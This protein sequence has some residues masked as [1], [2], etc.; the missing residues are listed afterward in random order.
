MRSSQWHRSTVLLATTM[1]LGCGDARRADDGAGALHD[2]GIETEP[3]R[4]S[5][6]DRRPKFDLEHG[7]LNVD[8]PGYA[9]RLGVRGVGRQ[10]VIATADRASPA[11]A[12]HES[13]GRVRYPYAGFSE[14]FLPKGRGVEH[15]IDVETRPSGDGWLRVEIDT[16]GLTPRL[17]PGRGRVELNHPS[18][19]TQLTYGDLAVVDATGRRL[20]ARFAVDA[21]GLAIEVADEGA[22]YPLHIDPLVVGLEEAVIDAPSTSRPDEI[23]IATGD[24]L[25]FIGMPSVSTP[26]GANVG[27]VLVY[28]KVGGSWTKVATV[29]SSVDAPNEWFGSSV[30][31]QAGTLYVGA[32][33]PGTLDPAHSSTTP[34]DAGTGAVTVFTRSG[35]T[36]TQQALLR[37]SD[38]APGDG[39][40]A[41]LA[42]SGNTLAVAQA[43]AD[44]VILPSRVYVFE[45]TGGS[46]SASAELTPTSSL[47]NLYAASVAL[48]G[49][50]L[51]VGAPYAV[52]GADYNVGVGFVFSRG[53]SGWTQSAEL[54]D[55]VCTTTN[56]YFGQGVGVSGGTVMIGT[57]YA[58]GSVA[59]V[60]VYQNVAGSWTQSQRLVAP[61]SATVAGSMLGH[62]LA[63]A[64]TTAWI[65]DPSWSGTIAGGPIH[66]GG[67]LYPATADASG[68]WSL[69]TPV[70]P[71]DL[72]LRQ[73]LGFAV[74]F[75]GDVLVGGD[76]NSMTV[77]GVAAN[78]ARIFGLGHPDG[79][80]CTTAT[81]TC[82]SGWCVDG[83]CCDS[84]CTDTC[85]SCSAAKKGSGPDGVCA[86]IGAG[87]D[88][89]LECTAGTCTSGVV[90][91]SPGCSGTAAGGCAPLKMTSCSP[92]QCN[93]D[94]CGTS[95]AADRDCDR[96]AA[97]CSHGACVP[98]HHLG[99]TCTGEEEC[100]P[101]LHCLDGVC[102]DG[103][104]DG[105]CSACAKAVTGQPDG[106]CVPFPAGSKP[107]WGCDSYCYAGSAVHGYCDGTLSY[108]TSQTE[109][110][111]MDGCS[112]AD[113]VATCERRCSSATDC[114]TGAV[115]IGGRCV[116]PADLGAACTTDAGCSGGHCVDGVCCESACGGQC[117][118]C[119]E[120]GGLGHCLTVSGPPRGGRPAC[121]GD[122]S[123][124]SAKCGGFDP[125][126][127]VTPARG[128]PCGGC[129]AGALSACDGS[130]SCV[131]SACPD[132]LACA[133]ALTC[134]TSCASDADCAK[135]NVCALAGG[136]GSCVL[137]LV[138]TTDAHGGGCAAAPAPF[139]PSSG[140]ELA[141]LG[142]LALTLAAA[143]RRRV[144]SSRGRR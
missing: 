49:D 122:G 63:I 20:E 141:A 53:P 126:G 68:H 133:D 136:V 86:P 114:S 23:S 25:V 96:L 14:W 73:Q 69:G 93:G 5:L 129:N 109:D 138:A 85:F 51:V 24:G 83:V 21:A 118:S 52:S 57:G 90:S 137:P 3:R 12:T 79:D 119:N 61:S 17:P 7:A 67:A 78:E 42:I 95:C 128:I 4:A 82:N 112:S 34:A 87:L 130:G 55:A 41:A 15:G 33:E 48:D 107:R 84:Q 89:D 81:G 104:C 80:P 97:Y 38:G 45:R 60:S 105:S 127:C 134:A 18:G 110:C 36:F 13:S 74:A 43:T 98:V 54:R 111:G 6:T 131:A 115:C 56:C 10:G 22:R 28:Q 58:G 125:N 117:Q 11:R 72:V 123:A 100:A 39:F 91:R 66:P 26:T 116:A 8:G 31:Y 2:A 29:A 70:A 47:S 124:C 76:R 113:G 16:E 106:V 9:L 1:A 50:T 37:A 35:L 132:G 108:C 30:A 32:V 120:P 103:G 59:G 135:G 121:P 140:S 77:A 142:A 139:Q 40:G 99:E 71:G 65:G 101:S 75:D 88:P 46:W 144:P 19:S 143:R 92:Y 64:G 27:A 44:P 94:A 102:C 62:S